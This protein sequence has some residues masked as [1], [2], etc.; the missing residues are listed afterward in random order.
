MTNNKQKADLMNYIFSRLGDDFG[1]NL[2]HKYSK[3]NDNNNFYFRFITSQEC[4]TQIM[5]LSVHKPLGSPLIPAWGLRD[6]CSELVEPLTMIFISFISQC[7][8][9]T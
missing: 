1:K 4:R 9:Q 5:K 8:F 6:G 7:S 3:N 2:P